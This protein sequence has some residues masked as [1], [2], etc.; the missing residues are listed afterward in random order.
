MGSW[1]KIVHQEMPSSKIVKT[2]INL[3]KIGNSPYVTL[4]CVHTLL[5]TY[6]KLYL[7]LPFGNVLVIGHELQTLCQL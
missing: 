3:S 5:R 1:L 4:Y 2:P 6:F 7:I